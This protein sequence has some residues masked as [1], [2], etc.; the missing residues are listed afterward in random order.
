MKRR[1]I[2]ISDLHLPTPDAKPDRLLAFLENHPC[3]TLIINGDLIDKRYLRFFGKR[4]AKH[5]EILRQ[6]QQI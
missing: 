4:E 3:E 6:I 5:D 2:V 1:T